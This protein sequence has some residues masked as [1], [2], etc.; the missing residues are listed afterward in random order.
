V[1]PPVYLGA[2]RKVQLRWMNGT[3]GDGPVCVWFLLGNTFIRTR[4]FHA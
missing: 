1:S 2:A 4:P 3:P